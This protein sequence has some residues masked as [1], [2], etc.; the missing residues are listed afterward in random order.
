MTEDKVVLLPPQSFDAE[1][2]VLGALLKDSSAY[3]IVQPIITN[4]DF[5]NIKHNYI[6]AAI[7]SLGDAQKPRDITTVSDELIKRGKLKEAGGRVYL[8]ELAAEGVTAA[9]IE[10][11]AKIVRDKAQYRATINFG[12]EIVRSAYAQ[13]QSIEHLVGNM[14][15]FSI[16]LLGNAGDSKFEKLG[17]I[18]TGVIAGTD[19]YISGKR[20]GLPTSFMSLDELTGGFQRGD[21]IVLAGMPKSGKTA[22]S[23]GM[24]AVEADAGFGVGY[25][26]AETKKEDFTMRALCTG[27]EVDSLHWKTG[28]LTEKQLM[29][30]NEAGGKLH[31][32]PFWVFDSP[33]LEIESLVAQATR[34]KND[35]NIDIIYIDYG[36]LIKTRRTFRNRRDQM[37]YIIDEM[38]ALAKTLDIPVVCLCQIRRDTAK[39]KNTRPMMSDLKETGA[40]EQNADL[41]LALHDPEA[42]KKKEGVPALRTR[43]FIILGQRNGP[44][45]EFQV[46]FDAEYTKFTDPR[47]D[48]IPF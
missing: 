46:F 7:S 27:A 29:E 48:E 21:F 32:W 30:I 19:D 24:A 22:C 26:S 47:A 18:A 2:S 6:F 1:R 43:E 11:H 37:D 14:G 36:Q 8:V 28:Q 15:R 45:G 5:Y 3:A 13:E 16:D 41:I 44:D 33:R 12:N 31:D 34:L 10:S 17:D 38:V 35:E 9:H 20:R 40:W 23:F 42:G 4:R 39:R 25:F